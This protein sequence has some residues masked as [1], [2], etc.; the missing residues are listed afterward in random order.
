MTLSDEKK[1]ELMETMPKVAVAGSNVQTKPGKNPDEA[2]SD[3][4]TEQS[5]DSSSESKLNYFL[6]CFGF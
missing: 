1:E 2:F 5:E 4:K 3:S 6:E